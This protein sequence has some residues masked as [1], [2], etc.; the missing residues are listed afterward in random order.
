MRKGSALLIV[1]GMISF[2]LFSGIAFSVYM[3][4]TRLP[5][6]FIRRTAVT[7]QLAKSA[8]SEAMCEINSCIGNDPHPGIPGP[9]KPDGYDFNTWYR[10]V[11]L[12]VGINK[13]K[14]DPD[15]RKRTLREDSDSYGSGY[16][17]NNVSDDPD[18]TTVPTLSLEGLTYLPPS[19][20]N[21][22]RVY[23]RRTPTAQWTPFAFEAGRFAFTAIDVSDYFDVNRVP[24]DIHRSS[25]S[26][27]RITLAHVFEEAAASRIA[28]TF[29]T[30]L[31]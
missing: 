20:V 26:S 21:E 16:L 5:S 17:K 28:F 25:A 18:E 14:T 29:S 3:R 7:R 8:L 30:S 22:A 13:G 15:D 27:S 1:L 9:T 10:R 2:M 11:F 4:Q 24:V 12:G 19:L 23:S 6:S 31:P